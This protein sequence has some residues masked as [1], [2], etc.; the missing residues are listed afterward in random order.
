MSAL[1]AVLFDWDGTLSDSAEASFRCYARL[2]PEYGIPFARDDYRRTYSPDW[3]RTYVQLGL[4]EEHW[5]EADARWLEYYEAEP[6]CEMAGGIDAVRALG[7]AGL[8]LG[9]VTSG[10]RTRVEREL[11]GLDLARWFETVV[12]SGDTALRKPH[13]APLLVAMD[14]MGVGAHESAYVGDS[15]EDVQMARAA[16]VYAIGIPGPF[17]NRELLEASAPDLLAASLPEAVAALL[18][19]R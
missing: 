5:K 3:Y 6:A 14:R 1:R 11:A 15:P 16:G 19:R 12:C 8:K 7:E 2:F 10:S 9:L 13:P 4:P 18:L 17:P